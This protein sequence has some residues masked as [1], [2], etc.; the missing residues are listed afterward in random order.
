[1]I[2]NVLV[3][4]IGGGAGLD[5][6]AIVS[7]LAC[8]ASHRPVVVVHGVSARMAQ[9]CAARGMPVEMLHSPG[10]HSSRYTPPPV[11]DLFVEAAGQINAEIVAALHARR[12]PAS[13]LTQPVVIQG[14]RKTALRAVVN[15]RVRVI[16]DDYT[17]TITGVKTEPIREALHRGEIAVIP[18]LAGSPEG[19]LNV[20]GD[21]AAAAVAA[22]LRAGALVFLSNVRGLYRNSQD[23]SSFV[24]QVF[25][26]QFQQALSWAEGRMKRKVLSAQEARS[27]GVAHVVM[28]DGRVPQPVTLALQ[29][30]GT[31]FAS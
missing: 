15:G 22:S 29:G 6:A 11:R 5:I 23:D 14:A 30:E 28:A 31:V 18:P 16:R 13:G 24:S 25:P 2:E 27:A 3:V 12:A 10:G 4:K 20:D 19:L 7:D 17:G 21:R 9:L 26:S 8:I 1:M